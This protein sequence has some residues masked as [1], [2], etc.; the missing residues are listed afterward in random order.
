ML[1]W[2]K[3]K[4]GIIW[5]ESRIRYLEKLEE[6]IRDLEK[7]MKRSPRLVQEAAL[8]DEWVREMH[9]HPVG[10]PKYIAFKNRLDS[11]GYRHGE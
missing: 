7:L 6:R 3:R 5:L 11:L 4:L 1:N 8:L 2:I 10:S 9:T